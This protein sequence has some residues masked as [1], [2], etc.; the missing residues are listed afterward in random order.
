MFIYILLLI[1]CRNIEFLIFRRLESIF[2]D[3]GFL[4]ELYRIY[5]MFFIDFFFVG[6]CVDIC[7]VYFWEYF[8]IVYYDVCMFDDIL[9]F[10]VKI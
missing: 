4:L 5:S 7:R 10:L 6:V 3:L 2:L 8:M 1:F 9:L